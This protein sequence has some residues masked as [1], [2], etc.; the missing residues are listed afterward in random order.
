MSEVRSWPPARFSEPLSQDFPSAADWLVPLAERVWRLPGGRPLVL[1]YW[2]RQ[3]LRHLLEV[4]PP[5][6]PMAGQL[7]YR[8]VVILVA[9]Q[10]GKSLVAA[11]LALYG[12]IREA[13]A[14]VIGLASSAEQARIVQHRT[15]VALRSH[16]SL[17]KRFKRLTDTRGLEAADGSRY[18][19]KAAKSAAVQGLDLS[20]GIAD[21]LH[22]LKPE[23]W[24]DLVTGTT[25]R[26]NGLVVG[27]S[28]E[29]DEGSA[30]LIDLT[31]RIVDGPGERF[32]FFIWEAPID[33][34]PADDETFADCLRAANPAIAE[35]RID[36][37]TAVSDA[38]SL[39]D[40]DVIRYRFNRRVSGAAEGWMPPHLWA[41]AAG[42]GI[43]ADYTGPLFV[44][45]D[46]TPGG[47]HASMLA[48]ANIDGAVYVDTVGTWVAPS[49][50]A[51]VGRCVALSRHRRITVCVDSYNKPLVAALKA[52]GVTVRLIGRGEATAAYARTY[53]LVAT[54]RLS[55]DGSQLLA[56]Q[57]P[58]GRRRG[59]SDGAWRLVRPTS[60][61]DL[62]AVYG[63]CWAV[64]VAETEPPTGRALFVAS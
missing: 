37:A 26:P 45:L 50:D 43:P 59:T 49:I 62:D 3:L 60:G 54:G 24:S 28:T 25:A 44:G 53:A 64:Y 20:L 8:Q 2:Q 31:K 30:L 36:I 55:H 58:S 52:R 12:L 35:G 5:G 14:L 47:E 1:D 38:R 11:L 46:M 7:R 48:V 56:R 27:I 61:A 63:L 42:D 9:R 15:L 51:L 34:V 57:V 18:E 17:A 22:L 10:A 16:P 23:L 13:G 33:Y 32:G 41:A 21:E 19:V 29:G 4:Y 40:R 6:H 39:P